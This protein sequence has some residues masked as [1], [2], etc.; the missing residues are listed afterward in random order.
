MKR[1]DN[2]K[3]RFMEVY[4]SR[5]LAPTTIQPMSREWDHWGCFLKNRRPRPK[6]EDITAEIITDFIKSRSQFHAKSTQ[7]GVMSRMRMIGNFL[8]QENIWKNNLLNWMKGPKLDSR[9]QLPRRVG[10]NA[11]KQIMEA[12]ATCRFA[13]SRYLWPTV[14][15]I[16]YGTGMRRSELSRLNLSSWNAEEGLLL[17]EHLY[18][19]YSSFWDTRILRPRCDIFTLLDRNWQ[20]P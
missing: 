3:D 18:R 1:W 10:R 16:Y 5:G 7:Q 4:E 19:M 11:L 8:V 13:Y 17:V 12:A 14:L 2:L 15:S 6:L 20:R 9:R